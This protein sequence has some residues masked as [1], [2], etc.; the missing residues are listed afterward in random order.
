[1]GSMGKHG[2][3]PVAFTMTATAAATAAYKPVALVPGLI[4]VDR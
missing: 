3:V 4:G 1:M 2:R